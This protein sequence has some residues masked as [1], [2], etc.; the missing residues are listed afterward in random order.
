MSIACR[1]KIDTQKKRGRQKERKSDEK[2]EYS[3]KE[4]D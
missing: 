4:L 3:M 1:N 2:H